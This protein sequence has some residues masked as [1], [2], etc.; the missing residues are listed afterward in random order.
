MSF[1]KADPSLDDLSPVT[2]KGDLMAR[3]ASMI[4]R[5][6]VGSDGSALLADSTQTTG[7]RWGSAASSGLDVKTLTGATTLTTSNDIVYVSGTTFVVTLYDP[8]G[9]SGKQV[10]IQ[11]TD[12]ATT[13]QSVIG[14]G[15]A[16]VTLATQNEGFRFIADGSIWR[17]ADHW[18]DYGMTIVSA[19]GFSVYTTGTS[20]PVLGTSFFNSQ[21]GWERISGKSARFYWTH[22]Q[23]SANGAVAGN[24][25]YLFPLP[26]FLHPSQINTGIVGYSTVVGNAAQFATRNTLPSSGNVSGAGDN[27]TV[28]MSVYN[29]TFVRAFWISSTS[30]GALCATSNMAP[31]NTNVTWNFYCDVIIAGW[32]P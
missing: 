27:G 22:G 20:N 18:W 15:L 30:Q 4:A 28:V 29:A 32:G 7:L 19:A 31:T 6:P 21:F 26:N 10:V 23:N 1:F 3:N 5:L 8:T 11:K 9:N 2:T 17:K 24:G 25:D 16:G 13:A 12:A 14:T